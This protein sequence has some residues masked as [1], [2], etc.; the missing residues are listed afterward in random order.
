MNQRI[1]FSRRDGWVALLCFVG[2][3][4]LY[5]LTLAPGVVALDDDSLEFQLLAQRGGIAHPTGYPLYAILLWLAARLF[6]IGE[7]AT[8]AN[9][10]SAVVAAATVALTYLV[11]RRSGVGLGAAGVAAALFAVT[12]LFWAHATIAEVYALHLLLSALL[13]SALLR[14]ASLP[15]L[16]LIVGLGVAHHRMIVLWL[17]AVLLY[18]ALTRREVL[19]PQRQWLYAAAAL[20]LPLLLYL[21]LPLRA[22]VGS[23]DGT[24]RQVGFSCWVRACQYEQSFFG[25][26]ELA[27]RVPFTFFLELTRQEMGLIGVLLAGIGFIFLGV[28]RPKIALF[29]SLAVIASAAFA[30]SFIVPD[31]EVY[32]LPVLWILAI[33]VGWGVEGIAHTV[34]RVAHPTV[35][36]IRESPQQ[37]LIVAL[38]VVMALGWV[39]TRA[40]AAFP[41][42]D[43]SAITMPTLAGET[44]NGADILAQPLPDN[45]TV[46][47]LLGEI[48][49]LQY[50]Q[51]AR[52]LSPTVATA[53]GDSEEAR[54]TAIERTLAAGRRPFLTRPLTS[55]ESRGA[56]AALGPLLELRPTPMTEV[57]SGLTAVDVPM[58]EGI[59]LRGWLLSPIATSGD[60]RLTLAWH[61]AGPTSEPLAVSV[62]VLDAAG[63]EVDSRDRPPLRGAYP[64]TAWHPDEIVQDTHEIAPAPTGESYLVILY[65]TSDGHEVGRAMLG[66]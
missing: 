9:L 23:V 8:R 12:P 52:G 55:I 35:G 54:W 32:W 45:A 48:A 13:V 33:L 49:Y 63:D 53:G 42:A 16:A 39:A 3:L 4:L 50:L 59:T 56:V 40:V 41:A 51:E 6:P 31:R 19:R 18:L 38:C 7:V 61:A 37:R 66:P 11:A 1:S 28:T 17:P 20:M 10:L 26:N 29:F 14:G 64:T 2:A 36:T 60:M 24:Y 22:E 15:V 44:I 47:G 43:R 5:G 25:N 27:Q 30:M 21:W 62:R 58:G 65:R 57:P 46:V 34:R